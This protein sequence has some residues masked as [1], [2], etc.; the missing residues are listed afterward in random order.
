M[1]L[2]CEI[3][4]TH[5]GLPAK[6]VSHHARTVDAE[7]VPTSDCFPALALTRSV[8]L[9]YCRIII[10][11]SVLNWLHSRCRIRPSLWPDLRKEPIAH[12]HILILFRRASMQE[13]LIP[14][15]HCDSRVQT[16][17]ADVRAV[18]PA[19]LLQNHPQA[20]MKPLKSC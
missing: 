11:C 6:N 5:Y 12:S 19:S 8:G 9:H 4:S 17:M 18:A 14:K 3:T 10:R 2:C 16:L 20:S 1:T 7:N 15:Q 13:T